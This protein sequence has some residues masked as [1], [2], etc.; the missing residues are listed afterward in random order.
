MIEKVLSDADISGFDVSFEVTDGSCLDPRALTD[1]LEETGNYVKPENE[2]YN[3]RSY[4]LHGSNRSEQAD[5]AL[6][7]FW[8]GSVE[9]DGPENASFSLTHTETEKIRE[10]YIRYT[11]GYRKGAAAEYEET[12]IREYDCPVQIEDNTISFYGGNEAQLYFSEKP[13]YTSFTRILYDKGAA[14]DPE[15]LVLEKKDNGTW[16]LNRKKDPFV[17]SLWYFFDQEQDIKYK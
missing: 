11:S 14:M 1:Y 4:R 3:D 15:E 12:E 8:S 2:R 5:G 6:P 16:S 17:K 13:P 10:F 7:E 9:F